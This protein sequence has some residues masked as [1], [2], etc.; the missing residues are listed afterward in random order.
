M[1]E[2]DTI[3]RAARTLE[4]A[5]AGSRVTDFRTVLAQLSRVDDDQPLRGRLIERVTAVGKH[6]LVQFEGDLTLRTH[7]RMNGSWHIYRRGEKWQRPASSMRLVIATERFEAV[8]F[9]IQVAEFIRTSELG[10]DREL[11]RLGP[12]VLSADFDPEEALRRLRLHP[13]DTIGDV[14]LNQTVMAG[15]GNVFKS[16]ILFLC[17]I[18]PFHRVSELSDSQLREVIS[19][20]RQL[21]LQNVGGGSRASSGGFRRTTRRISPSESLWVYGRKGLPCRKCGAP[22]AWRKVGGEAR[23]TYWCP[24][25][26]PATVAASNS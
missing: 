4:R 20:S 11:A 7:M 17:K 2:G 24:R 9:D 19:T 12:D 21:L 6:L 3:F 18:D 13:N 22:V 8:A 26:Q 23:S 5:L 10:R 16:E 14:L 25:C 1:P 15:V